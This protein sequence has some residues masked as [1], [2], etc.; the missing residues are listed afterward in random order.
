M[1]S[2]LIKWALLVALAMAEPATAQP[3][4]KIFRL[5]ILGDSI[6]AG[7]GLAPDQSFPARLADELKAAGLGVAVIDDSV[8]GDTSAGGLAR[9]GDALARRP[10]AVLLELGGNDALRAIDPKVTYANLDQILAR[11]E[12]ARIP[13]LILGMRSPAN[14]GEDYQRRFDAIYPRLAAAHG[15]LLYPFLLD[16]VALDPK[17]NQPDLIHPNAAGAAIIARRLVP[18]VMLLISRSP[19]EP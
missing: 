1:A 14:W 18:D 15:D 2:R 7:Y 19:K 17:L 11:F 6:G 9:V 16:Q 13:V 10:D 3:Q 12:A 8:S 5:L 4:A